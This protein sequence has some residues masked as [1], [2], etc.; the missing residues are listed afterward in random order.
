MVA[1]LGTVC[2]VLL[3]CVLS[4]TARPL[5]FSSN[6]VMSILFGLSIVL[7]RYRSLPWQRTSTFNAAKVLDRRS[8]HPFATTGQHS[9]VS[10]MAA[11]DYL[12]TQLEGVSVQDENFD[13]NAPYGKAKV[14]LTGP[15]RSDI[16]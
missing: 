16:D 5:K 4:A 14:R 8:T 3:R 6:A 11:V 9:T 7:A 1:V 10:S 15:H 2:Y 13:S 12:S